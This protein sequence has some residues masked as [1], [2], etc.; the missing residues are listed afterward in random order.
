MRKHEIPDAAVEAAYAETPPD[1]CRYLDQSDIRLILEAAFP[2]MHRAAWDAG[3]TAAVAM[4][5][6][7][8]A[9]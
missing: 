9:Q 4:Q 8:T 3:F 1:A 5:E 7:R 6:F 2:H